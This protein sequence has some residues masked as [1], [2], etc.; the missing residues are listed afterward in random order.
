MKNSLKNSSGFTLVEIMVVSV[1]MIVVI[2]G[3]MTFYTDS[4][5]V[6]LRST[7]QMELNGN[8]R[9]FVERMLRDVQSGS[10]VKVYNNLQSKTLQSAGGSGNLIVIANTYPQ[11]L[12]SLIGPSADVDN[13]G[14]NIVDLV[15]YYIP[16][17]ATSDGAFP[18]IRFYYD[19]PD[20]AVGATS[21]N[22][23]SMI[24]SITESGGPGTRSTVLLNCASSDVFTDRSNVRLGLVEF[25]GRVANSPRSNSA[26]SV[27]HFTAGTR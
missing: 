10:I 5:R 12:S 20:V 16:T 13:S 21:P 23:A 24:S 3:V 2:V 26:Y 18:I 11:Q 8:T 6:L 19:C 15:G 17:T 7:N 9:L 27:I 14:V 22:L 1:I 25:N 4:S